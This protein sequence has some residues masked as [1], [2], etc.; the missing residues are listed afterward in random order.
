M[1][2][3]LWLAAAAAAPPVLGA[4]TTFSKLESDLQCS[5]CR[6]LAKGIRTWMQ[7]KA[8]TW[9]KM[10]EAEK[11][12]WVAKSMKKA[13]RVPEQVATVERNGRKVFADFT[14]LMSE[15]GSHSGLSLSSEIKDQLKNACEE[16]A[17]E[18]KDDV[19]I[20]YTSVKKPAKY[21]VEDDLCIEL[22]SACG[23]PNPGE[24]MPPDTDE[25]DATLSKWMKEEL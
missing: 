17:V 8:R 20:G 3:T 1:L 9:K 18:Y 2:V 4:M 12:K 10:S 21:K 14:Q 13:C 24:W 6:H 19:V 5:A 15:G 23:V 11:G 7:R 25:I 16:L 22:T